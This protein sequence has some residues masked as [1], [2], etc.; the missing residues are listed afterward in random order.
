MAVACLD[1]ELHADEPQDGR[2]AVVQIDKALEQ[3]ADEEEQLAQAHEGEG[4]RRED[5]EGLARQAEGGGYRVEREHEVGR[6]DGDD[7]QEERRDVRPAVAADHHP[8]ADEPVGDPE[9][10]LRGPHEAVGFVLLVLLVLRRVLESLARLAPRGPQEEGREEE[11]EPREALQERGAQQDEDQAE[12]QGDDDPPQKHLLLVFAG[13]AERGDDD[14]ED[15]DVVDGQRILREVGREVF[16]GEVGRVPDRRVQAEEHRQADVEDE[17]AGALPHGRLV[18]PAQVDHEIHSDQPDDERAEDAPLPHV[19]LHV[20]RIVLGGV[21]HERREHRVRIPPVVVGHRRSL[22]AIAGLGPG[23]FRDDEP[24]LGGNT[25]LRRRFYGT[26]AV[27]ALGR[28]AP[29]CGIRYAA[30]QPGRRGS[31]SGSGYF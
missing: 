30:A 7:A 11:E 9:Y 29:A 16:V 14:D 4:V 3:A 31:R 22:P 15:E 13:H 12:G 21:E 17:P 10:P 6:S 28:P 5:D 26:V 24:M 19:H 25:P 2:Q 20:E 27:S 18:G 23:A 8:I 1:E